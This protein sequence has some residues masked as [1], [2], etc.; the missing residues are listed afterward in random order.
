MSVQI[1]AE[2]AGVEPFDFVAVGQR[3]GA[4]AHRRKFAVYAIHP[5]RQIA[6]VKF[7]NIVYSLDVGK[8]VVAAGAGAFHLYSVG[9]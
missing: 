7:I 2:V 5:T 6:A 9:S 1:V 4:A 8:A 3:E